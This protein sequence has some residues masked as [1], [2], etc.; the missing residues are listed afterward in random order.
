MGNDANTRK[1]LK[2]ARTGDVKTAQIAIKNGANINAK[3]T[4]LQDT[5]LHRAAVNGH[6]NIMKLLVENGADINAVN[7]ENLSAL[8]TPLMYFKSLH[9]ESNY[10]FSIVVE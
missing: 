1:L 2:A 9:D 8:I 6:I 7:Y 4:A 5:A 10:N 3:D